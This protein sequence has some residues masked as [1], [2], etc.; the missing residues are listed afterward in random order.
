MGCTYHAGVITYVTSATIAGVQAGV[1][2]KRLE[3]VDQVYCIENRRQPAIFGVR[4][5]A[6]RVEIIVE[7]GLLRSKVDPKIFYFSFKTVF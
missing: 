6:L 2:I 5:G 1:D 7:G 3:F 4:L